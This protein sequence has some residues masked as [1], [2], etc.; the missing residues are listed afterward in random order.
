MSQAANRPMI[1]SKGARTRATFAAARSF[2]RF[3]VIFCPDFT[4][5]SPVLAS[6][7]S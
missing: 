2:S 3:G 7:M 4:T 1:A 6:T 5:T